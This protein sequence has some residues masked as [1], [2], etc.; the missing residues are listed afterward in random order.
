MYS[1]L[2]RHLIDLQAVSSPPPS[3]STP[4]TAQSRTRDRQPGTPYLPL[5]AARTTLYTRPP[6]IPRH[7]WPR[8]IQSARP[9]D[10]RPRL[11]APSP[12]LRDPAC[13]MAAG[14]QDAAT[15]AVTRLPDTARLLQLA[16]VS[17]ARPFVAGELPHHN[18]T[19][20]RGLPISK[21]G[22]LFA[23]V[24]DGEDDALVPGLFPDSL[25][26]VIAAKCLIAMHLLN[27]P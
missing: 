16:R 5:I 7:R 19:R 4:L 15:L 21:P 8:S 22:A 3:T 23:V 24:E 18:A 14:V 6:G 13:T 12:P 17:A 25:G 20:A 27:T 9:W 26:V 1:P 11:C 10:E 2:P